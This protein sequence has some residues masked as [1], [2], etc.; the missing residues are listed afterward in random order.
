MSP[1]TYILDPKGDI[2][3]ILINPNAKNFQ[4]DSDTQGMYQ[5]QMQSIR[6][7]RKWKSCQGAEPSL[8]EWLQRGFPEYQ[9]LDSVRE[10]TDSDTSSTELLSEVS[11]LR[12]LSGEEPA[13]EWT[14]E[15]S[16]L[17]APPI[18]DSP[19]EEPIAEEAAALEP[20]FE[21]TSTEDPNNEEI[22]IE[23]LSV[24]DPAAETSV[25]E[26]AGAGGP[27]VGQSSSPVNENPSY[28]SNTDDVGPETNRIRILASSSHLRLASSVLRRRLA[29]SWTTNNTVDGSFPAIVEYDWDEDDFLIVLKAMHGRYR[30]LPDVDS[31][32]DLASIAAIVDYYDCHESIEFKADKWISNVSQD[33]PT[34]F[35][36]DAMLLWSISWV[37]SQEPLF[38]DMTELARMHSRTFID[39]MNLP[40]PEQLLGQF[41]KSISSLYFL[42]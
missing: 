21:E 24:G 32:Q 17:E 28:T 39:N 41:F 15:P 7:K 34:T 35:G 26:V 23:G 27:S 25:A 11:T 2:E 20:A 12:D 29:H 31:L 19:A 5:P 38:D 1:Y 37:F 3:I 30:D 6:K 8:I 36:R 9:C 33:L 14:G 4:W 40:L 16:S 42:L 18:E 13:A 10:L 22:P